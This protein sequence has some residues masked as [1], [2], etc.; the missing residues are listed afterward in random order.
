MIEFAANQMLVVSNMEDFFS[1]PMFQD[2]LIR[3]LSYCHQ[4][5]LVVVEVDLHYIVFILV[6]DVFD[7]GNFFGW[8][9]G[10]A[11]SEVIW[12]YMARLAVI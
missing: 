3:I 6:K 1:S 10:V 4:S 5:F 9:E 8:I 12:S 7:P 11:L 2:I